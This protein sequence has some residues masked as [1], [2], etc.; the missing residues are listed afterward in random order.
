MGQAHNKYSP[1]YK[2]A[3]DD[4]TTSI[5]LESGSL[6]ANSFYYR[7]EATKISIGEK[8]GCADFVK[9][10]DLGLKLGCER[11]DALC[12]PQT[13]F[14]PYKKYFGEGIHGG[15]HW[16]DLDNTQSTTDAL[17]VLKN[18]NTGVHQCHDTRTQDMI[19]KRGHL[20]ATY[21]S[22]VT[23]AVQKVAQ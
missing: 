20:P 11:Y 10:C 8:A 19:P 6:N 2:K 5:N 18:I 12:Y 3:I 21:S 16:I 7:G 15:N 4:F 14:M 22:A 23:A 17:V 1:L 13:G 9:A